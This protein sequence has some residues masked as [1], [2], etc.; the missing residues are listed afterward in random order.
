MRKIAGGRTGARVPGQEPATGRRLI[1]I[2][3]D[4]SRDRSWATALVSVFV[5]YGDVYMRF[6]V[7]ELGVGL[8]G[9]RPL[10]VSDPFPAARAGLDDLKAQGAWLD[11][12]RSRL[13]ELQQRLAEDGWEPSGH[14]EHWWS[15]RYTRPRPHLAAPSAVD[16]PA[17]AGDRLPPA[18]RLAR[19]APGPRRPGLGGRGPGSAAS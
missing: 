8:R 1:E 13:L 2:V 14:G 10:H 9:L 12:Q 16:D 3:V 11:I 4:E 19:R 18:R 5:P 17:A 15:A 6:V 7:R